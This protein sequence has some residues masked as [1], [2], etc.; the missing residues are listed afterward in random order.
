VTVARPHIVEGL[1][2]MELSRPYVLQTASG[3]TIPV[4]KEAQVELTL[5]RRTL[6]IWVLVADITDDFI[7]G[8]DILRNYDASANV[9]H[10]VL[11]LGRDEVPVRETSTAS[12]LKRSRPAESSKNSRPL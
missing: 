10:H 7:L 3:E 6:R 1:P 2:E 12:V 5:G 4:V 9:G 11:R 8:L